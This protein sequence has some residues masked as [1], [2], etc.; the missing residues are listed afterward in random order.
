MLGVLKRKSIVRVTVFALL[1]TMVAWLIP[2]NV[3]ESDAATTTLKNPRTAADGTVT[4]DC[5]WFGHYTQSSNGNGGFNDDPIKWRVLSVDGNE[6]L[7]LADKNLDTRVYNNENVSVTWETSPLRSWLNGSGIDSFLGKAFTVEE[8]AAI[9][10]KTSV[11]LGKT[12]KDKVVLLSIDEVTNTSYGFPSNL[13]DASKTRVAVNTDYVT[14]DYGSFPEYVGIGC[15]WLQKNGSGTNAPIVLWDG[16][17]N[18]GAATCLPS[19]DAIRPALYLNLSSGCWSYAGTVSSDGTMDE[20]WTRPGEQ[21]DPY[22]PSNDAWG[23]TNGTFS[24]EIPSISEDVW[25]RMF[26]RNYGNELLYLIRKN[27]TGKIGVCSGLC[28]A[29]ALT[30]IGKP[31]IPIWMVEGEK[32]EKPSD[33]RA[34]DAYLNAPSIGRAFTFSEWIQA[35]HVWQFTETAASENKSNKNQFEQIIEKTDEFHRTNKNPITITISG[36][37]SPLGAQKYH[38]LLPYR[39]EPDKTKEDGDVTKLYVYDPNRRC[40]DEEYI[41]FTHDSNGRVNGWKYRIFEDK[42]IIWSSDGG[43]MS[44]NEKFDAIDFDH[45][46]NTQKSVLLCPAGAAF[47]ITA[48]NGKQVTYK[49]GAVTGDENTD[50]IP[51][52]STNNTFASEEEENAFFYLNKNNHIT[53]KS[54]NG[55][56]L[57]TIIF[58]DDSSGIAFTSDGQSTMELSS[59]D[60]LYD[61]TITPSDLTKTANV[62]FTTDMGNTIIDVTGKTDSKVIAHA[63]KK[64]EKMIVTGYKDVTIQTTKGEQSGTKT[65]ENLSADTTYEIGVREN[66]E[67]V[68]APIKQTDP[69]TPST[70]PTKPSVDP[71][72]PTTSPINPT[73]TPTVSPTEP[74]TPSL[75][76][77]TPS[78]EPNQPSEEPTNPE[79]PPTNPTE[80]TDPATSGKL[81]V[82]GTTITDA[83]NKATYIITKTGKT[84]GTVTYVKPT[85]KTVTTVIVPSTI[86]SNGITYKVTAIAPYA[87]KNCK[88]LKKVTIGNNIRIIGKGAFIGCGKLKT[89]NFGKNVT[90][91]G[92]QAF[93]KC[94]ALTKVIIPSKVV[95][96][97][98]KAFFGCK[99]LKYITIKTRKLTSKRV[100]ISAFKGTSVKA[101]VKAPKGKAKTYKKLLQARGLNKKARVK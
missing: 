66:G 9:Y 33:F 57:S 87:F 32:H 8:Q 56:N 52:Y 13:E 35:C 72:T 51:V 86:S 41:T 73:V 93:Y 31:P 11:E 24:L 38:E 98:K 94:T 60:G 16:T 71:I 47:C 40:S 79:N 76:P 18:S 92:D 78:T 96:I 6:A 42:D 70:E 89:V 37:T 88:W 21:T 81:P 2:V 14:A 85:K 95:K 19:K 67:I 34:I 62:V 61:A 74:T 101:F 23:S 68:I 39:V 58:A 28:V 5:V 44:Y 29:S 82:K 80:S 64:D 91:I 49:N 69:T 65:L 99:K 30:F 45:C 100:G 27:C 46:S 63:L 1:L 15:W 10:Q 20:T 77:T 25:F 55:K 12:I 97:G 7:L 84:G 50:I 43:S 17:V 22:L 59:K 53:I 90:T 4:W 75:K 26:E 83:K 36:R 48:S 54:E 3:Q